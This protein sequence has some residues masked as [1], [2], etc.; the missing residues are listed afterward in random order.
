MEGVDIDFL[1]ASLP[2]IRADFTGLETYAV[3]SLH[4]TPNATGPVQLMRR[5]GSFTSGEQRKDASP[6]PDPQRAP[7]ADANLVIASPQ[8]CADGRF[9]LPEHRVKCAMTVMGG[10]QDA[11]VPLD[12]LVGW[13]YYSQHG[14]VHATAA[15]PTSTGTDGASQARSDGSPV[16]AFSHASVKAVIRPNTAH[17][18]MGRDDST[19]SRG[20]R[21][22]ID[23][24]GTHFFHLD[25]SGGEDWVREVLIQ[26]C[27]V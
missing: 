3:R 24:V 19:S 15:A 16:D 22:F 12:N 13:L 23:P 8:E 7:S 11:M 26:T 14:P 9:V 1:R 2:V 5:D 4:G 21:L 27:I 25:K 18:G 6:V 17:S 10:G 20:V